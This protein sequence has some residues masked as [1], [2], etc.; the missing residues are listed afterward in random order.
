MN[1]IDRD[2]APAAEFKHVCDPA[3][4]YGPE[5][6]AFGAG[7]Y[8][9]TNDE[10]VEIH[11]ALDR[12]ETS[13]PLA[14]PDVERKLRRLRSELR[15]GVGFVVVRG[16]PIARYSKRKAEV[17][18]QGLASHFGDPVRSDDNRHADVTALMFWH[19]IEDGGPALI[20]AVSV[21]N[22]LV[23][24]RPD[25]LPAF[26]REHRLFGFCDGYLSALPGAATA[27]TRRDT[28]ALRAFAK[29]AAELRHFIAFETGDVLL[30]NNWVVLHAPIDPPESCVRLELAVEGFRPT[31]T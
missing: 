30:L 8:R 17:L 5:A 12:A 7:L 20:P 13:E 29:T 27:L 1:E 24:H 2:L 22:E 16:L 31:P 15:D 25:L 10:I 26:L 6:V 11:Q 21:Y 9:W 23:K 28:A 4:W 14:L 19:G 18:F 3:G